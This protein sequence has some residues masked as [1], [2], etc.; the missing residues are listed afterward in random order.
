VDCRRLQG[1]EEAVGEHRCGILGASMISES[2]GF[3]TPLIPELEAQLLAATPGTDRETVRFYIGVLDT[4]DRAVLEAVLRRHLQLA[5]PGVPAEAVRAALV[6]ARNR[7][8]DREVQALIA[9]W[10]HE[11]RAAPTHTTAHDEK[12]DQ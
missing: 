11:N 12:V 1:G 2:F 7:D 9:D 10:N 8:D 4:R 6:K 5:R 3:D